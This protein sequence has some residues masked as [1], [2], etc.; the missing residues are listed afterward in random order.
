MLLT[1]TGSNTFDVFNSFQF[2]Q[3]EEDSFT[4][5]HRNLAIPCS[6]HKEICKM[7]V[8]QR[9][10]NEEKRLLMVTQLERGLQFEHVKVRLQ[11]C[12]G[13]PMSPLG[14]RVQL[15]SCWEL[16][17]GRDGALLTD[18]CSR[19]HNTPRLRGDSTGCQ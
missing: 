2:S 12:L 14:K 15:W 7:L 5:L 17:M 13:E 8:T 1:V 9:Y 10:E 6:H 19:S 11:V 4:V 18:P 16:Q 3:A